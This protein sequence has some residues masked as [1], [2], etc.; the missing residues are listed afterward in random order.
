MPPEQFYILHSTMHSCGVRDWPAV[1]LSRV[2][3]HIKLVLCGICLSSRSSAHV[4]RHRQLVASCLPMSRDRPACTVL[5]ASP[6][7]SVWRLDTARK[8][9]R[10]TISPSHKHERPLACFAAPGPH[11]RPCMRHLPERA[12]ANAGASPPSG[13]FIP[14][15]F[16]QAAAHVNLSPRSRSLG[17]MHT[18]RCPAQAHLSG[19]IRY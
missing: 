4:Q 1:C 8:I 5:C 6:S 13:P 3:G 12:D 10:K 14:L 11:P 19:I 9:N 15:A 17:G 16:P 18:A 2:Q 7:S